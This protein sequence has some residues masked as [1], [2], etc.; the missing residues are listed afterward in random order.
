MQKIRPWEPRPRWFSMGCD[1]AGAGIK[2]RRKD[3]FP[4][5]LTD[6][7]VL[8]ADPSEVGRPI[9]DSLTTLSLRTSPP[10]K[11]GRAASESHRRMHRW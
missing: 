10:D 1:R 9:N 4:N 8:G 6:S 7:A 11:E 3:S 5:R 2:Q